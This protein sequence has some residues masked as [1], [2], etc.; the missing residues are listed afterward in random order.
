MHMYNSEKL[1]TYRSDRIS[2]AA[3]TQPMKP[4]MMMMTPV[5]ISRYV[6]AVYVMLGRS[7]AYVCLS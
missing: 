3:P 6:V 7:S 5:A 2:L 4:M 1:T